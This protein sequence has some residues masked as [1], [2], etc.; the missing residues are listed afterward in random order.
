MTREVPRDA[1]ISLIASSAN[2]PEL[3]RWDAV[4]EGSRVVKF[5]GTIA[6][7]AAARVTCELRPLL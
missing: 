5:F 4:G 2:T 1:R 6:E 7:A 3:R